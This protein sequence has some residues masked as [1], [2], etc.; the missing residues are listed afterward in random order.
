MPEQPPEDFDARL[1]A[2]RAKWEKER[3]DEKAEQAKEDR[4]LALEASLE[5]ALA[6]IA[7][8]DLKIESQQEQIDEQQVDLSICSAVSDDLAKGLEIVK[9]GQLSDEAKKKIRKTIAKLT[10]GGTTSLVTIV[11]IVRSIF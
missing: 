4:L 11:E 3:E 2:E 5:A 1:A 10:A 6:R 7:G 9:S 8:Q